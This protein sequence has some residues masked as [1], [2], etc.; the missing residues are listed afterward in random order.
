MKSMKYGLNIILIFQ[1]LLPGLITGC[2]EED[3][4]VTLETGEWTVE[5]AVNTYDEFLIQV[6]NSGIANIELTSKDRVLKTALLGKDSVY[7]FRNLPYQQ[8]IVTVQ[9]EGYYTYRSGLMWT[10]QNKSIQIISSLQPLPTQMKRIDSIQCAINTVVPQV[11]LR[12]VT[13]QLLPAGGRR[14]AVIFAG[15]SSEVSPRY[16]NYIS[17]VSVAQ[18][19]G[20]TDFQT[21]NIYDTFHL[22]GIAPG[23]KVYLTARLMTGATTSYIDDIS[24]LQ[25][26]LNLEDNTRVITSF[27]MP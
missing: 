14:N 22:A 10:Y 16:G 27:I 24:G 23:T 13:P 26:F 8:Y 12:L 1:L 3:N 17:W 25:V 18:N 7:S 5:V 11:Y 9:K 21:D 2:K 6:P 4:P 20:K 15:L 19:A